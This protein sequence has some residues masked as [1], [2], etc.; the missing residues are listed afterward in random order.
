MELKQKVVEWPSLNPPEMTGTVNVLDVI[1][2]EAGDHRDKMIMRW[3]E[4]IWRQWKD[5][6]DWV[7]EVVALKYN[8][9]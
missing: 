7:K 5:T 2:A 6:H 3:G 4:S 9:Q 1:N 8:L